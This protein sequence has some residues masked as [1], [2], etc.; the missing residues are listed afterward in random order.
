[1]LA[2]ISSLR[3]FCGSGERGT[4]NAGDSGGGYFVRFGS[5]W[6]QYGV[7]SAFVTDTAGI[8]PTNAT[9]V[10]TKVRPFKDW[11]E[12]VAGLAKSEK[13]TL[14]DREETHF[15]VYAFKF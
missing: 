2:S 7:I 3:T 9:A 10:Y 6:V 13:L 11:I 14:R 8:V 15:D 12:K 1:M 4:V 5:S